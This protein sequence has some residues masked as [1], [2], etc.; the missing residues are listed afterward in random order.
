M[1]KKIGTVLDEALFR[2]TKI[3]ALRQD[4]PIS[5]VISEALEEYLAA[6]GSPRGPGGIVASSFGAIPLDRETVEAVLADE[7]TYPEA[8]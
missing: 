2:R 7:E 4:T 5:E 3:E 6:K 8:G 1:K